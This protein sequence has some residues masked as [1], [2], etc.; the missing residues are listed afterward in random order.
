[1]ASIKQ[2]RDNLSLLNLLRGLVGVSPPTRIHLAQSKV[3]QPGARLPPPADM[4][5]R[6]RGKPSFG[7]R[8]SSR[9]YR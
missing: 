1:M 8:K 4:E 2:H 9:P 7:Q 5:A 3:S 6:R